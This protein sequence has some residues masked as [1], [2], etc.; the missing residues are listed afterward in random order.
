MT[1]DAFTIRS[2]P[3]SPGV[4]VI[5]P[6]R[7][8]V[9]TRDYQYTLRWERREGLSLFI[10][11]IEYSID[12]KVNFIIITQN[13]TDDGLNS[14]YNWLVPNIISPNCYIR[15]TVI[16]HINRTGVCESEKFQIGTPLVL[17]GN[18]EG[19]IQ[20]TQGKPIVGIKVYLKEK[21]QYHVDT[22]NDGYFLIGNI[23]CGNYTVIIE[24]NSYSI[25]TTV[26]GVR[27]TPNNVTNIG[28][29]TLDEKPPP[30]PPPPPVW[31]LLLVIFIIIIL[32]AFYKKIKSTKK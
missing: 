19:W 3:P 22:N 13:A 30:P 27:V 6:V 17:T 29:I 15:V 1:D 28:H 18:I 16:D 20:N 14:Q 21:S 26:K 24:G 11:K 7:Y 4:R 25:G 31:L 12:S 10:T 32:I 2:Y 9:L 5:Y 23:S 8:E